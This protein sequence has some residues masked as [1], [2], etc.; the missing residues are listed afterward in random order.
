MDP[1]HSHAVGSKDIENYIMDGQIDEDDD[2]I[3]VD[4]DENGHADNLIEDDDEVEQLLAIAYPEVL[5]E[6]EVLVLDIDLFARR[7]LA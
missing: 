3:I 1:I 6:L 4:V 5:G 2:H 7:D